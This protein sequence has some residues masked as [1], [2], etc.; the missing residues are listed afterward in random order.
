MAKAGS[1]ANV[2]RDVIART[3]GRRA[4]DTQALGPDLHLDS[5][6]RAELLVALELALRCEA[7]DIVLTEDITVRDLII[8][9]QRNVA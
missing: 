5:D 6:D 7:D 4:H 3:C 8:H 2:I 1:P 9:L